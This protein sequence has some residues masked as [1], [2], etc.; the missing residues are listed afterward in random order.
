MVIKEIFLWGIL[1]FIVLLLV[2]G[3]WWR[4]RR[5][6]NLSEAALYQQIVD[7][8]ELVTETTAHKSI[9]KKPAK[10]T[11][12]LIIHL[13]IRAKDD[14]AFNGTDILLLMDNLS[15]EYGEMQLFHHY[16]LDDNPQQLPVFSVANMLEPGDFD[17]N[18]M[19]NFSTT[20]LIVFMR[21]PNVVDG[22]VAFELMLNHAQSISQ[23]LSAKL[24]NS[25][26]KLLKSPQVAVLR[27]QILTYENQ[28]KSI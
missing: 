12:D 23:Q 15:L 16:G 9:E 24:E 10:K 8:D 18:Q 14:K 21:L 2:I 5:Q 1:A 7:E 3:W 27:E 4:K 20:G 6:A 17:I 13:L 25:Q 22:R 28:K 11:D 19:M 26:G